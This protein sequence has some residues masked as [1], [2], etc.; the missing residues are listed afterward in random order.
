MSKKR[1]QTVKNMPL[2]LIKFPNV[3]LSIKHG[4]HKLFTKNLTPG[5]SFFGEKLIKKRINNKEIELRSFDFTHSKLGT[6]IIK[7][8][9][10]LGIR[11][12]SKVLYLGAS[13]GFTPSYVSDMVGKDGAVYCLDFAPRVVR[14]LYFL[15]KKRSNMAPLMEDANKPENY[16]DLIPDVDVIFMDISQRNQVQ[17]FLKNL[18]FLKPKG[19]A[20]LALKTRSI[21]ISKTPK[22]IFKE[23]RAELEKHLNIVDYKELDPYEKDHCIFVCKFKN[24]KIQSSK[25][26]K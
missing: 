13:H 7:K 8:I 19:F 17:I 5:I 11:E 16:K 2:T 9:S 12:G 3:Y 23:T 18:I 4:K 21:D 6:A 25:N 14:D 26:N 1:K 10:Q 15:C 20:I 24:E 22:Q